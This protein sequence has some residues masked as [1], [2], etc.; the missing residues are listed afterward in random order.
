MAKLA[1]CSLELA[2]SAP[3]CRTMNGRYCV[4]AYLVTHRQQALERNGRG[5]GGGFERGGGGGA[6]ST[7]GDVRAPPLTARSANAG[8]FSVVFKSVAASL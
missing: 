6:E 3:L 5:G 1:L 8:R 2:G 7:L 4:L